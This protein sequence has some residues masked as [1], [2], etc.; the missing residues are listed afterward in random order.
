M[1]ATG[2]YL[3]LDGACYGFEKYESM[4]NIH[5]FMLEGPA[6]KVVREV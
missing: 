3:W 1:E 4:E 5:L 6:N 2:G